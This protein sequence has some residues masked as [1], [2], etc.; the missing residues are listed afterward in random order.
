MTSLG[1]FNRSWVGVR[2]RTKSRSIK[3]ACFVTR[4]GSF[5]NASDTILLCAGQHYNTYTAYKHIRYPVPPCIA[6]YLTL[7]GVTMNARQKTAA[8]RCKLLSLKVVR[9]EHLTAQHLT[10][11]IF[12]SKGNVS[13]RAL[14]P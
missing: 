5:E 3:G 7:L 10:F 11:F 6:K 8:E 4:R 2:P 14:T 1:E 13:D 9:N 12:H